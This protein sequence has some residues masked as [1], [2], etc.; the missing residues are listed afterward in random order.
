LSNSKFT[1]AEQ[2]EWRRS[3]IREMQ[4]R[5]MNHVQIAHE[6]QVSKQLIGQD[7]KYLNQQAKN[8]MKEFLT[9]VFP[10]QFEIC[11]AA[12]D[13]IIDRSYKILSTTEDNRERLQAMDMYK[14]THITKLELIGSSMTID[15]ALNYIRGK[16]SGTENHAEQAQKVAEESTVF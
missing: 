8:S 6:F 7:I 12:L 13:S 4:A 16:Q 15:Q 1:K 10:G 2:I 11:L 3:K 14:S 5:G 9:E